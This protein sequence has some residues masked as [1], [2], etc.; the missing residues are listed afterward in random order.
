MIGTRIPKSLSGKPIAHV[1]DQIGAK[2][3]CVS[4]RDALTVAGLKHI[5][6][7]PWKLLH[8]RRVLVILQVAANEQFVVSVSSEVQVQSSHKCIQ[9]PGV[10]R[11]EREASEIEAVAYCVSVGVWILLHVGHNR[12]L[13]P[14]KKGAGAETGAV[15]VHG[16]ELVR[17]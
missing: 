16:C 14:R 1:V 4:Q 13:C 5:R 6:G 11:R 2:N 9:P 15:R 10:W 17:G 7:L 3:R 8:G 12:R